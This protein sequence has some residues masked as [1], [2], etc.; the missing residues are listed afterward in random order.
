[1]IDPDHPN[2]ATKTYQQKP[3][4]IIK[5]IPLSLT[6]TKVEGETVLNYIPPHP[7]NGTGTHRYSIV[8]LEQ[9]NGDKAE[10]SEFTT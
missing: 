1:M 2:E 10:L 6:Q 5:N 9:A 8:L 7:A 4:W 3:H